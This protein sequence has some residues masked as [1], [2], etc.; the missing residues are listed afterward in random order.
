MLLDLEV[1]CSFTL[2][3]HIITK[4]KNYTKIFLIIKII[5]G[6]VM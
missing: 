3:H 2:T 4:V 5:S 6:S 1:M